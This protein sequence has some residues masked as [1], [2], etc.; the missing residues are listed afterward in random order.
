M[1]AGAVADGWAL[2]A[3]KTR[4]IPMKVR[5][6]GVCRLVTAVRQH[7]PVVELTRRTVINMSG[8]VSVSMS[9]RIFLTNCAAGW[10]FR[11][12]ADWR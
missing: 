10:C 9:P 1:R 8:R 12:I 3:V 5:S 4:C 6:D 7:D 2:A 11:D